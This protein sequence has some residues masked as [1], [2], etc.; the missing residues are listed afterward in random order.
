MEISM[1]VGNQER[2]EHWLKVA[3]TSPILANLLKFCDQWAT[4][5][6]EF[7]ENR[8]KK[9]EEKGLTEAEVAQPNLS[10]DELYAKDPFGTARRFL[11][12]CWL[13]GD[14]LA[15]Q[16]QVTKD[17]ELELRSRTGTNSD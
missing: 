8:N 4:I 15:R 6:D 10:W 2:L 11:T 9:I 7:F 5:Y 3:E 12:E 1:Q 16:I 17:A 13:H 14:E